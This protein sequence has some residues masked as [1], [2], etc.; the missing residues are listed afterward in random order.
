ME[1]KTSNL[2]LSLIEETSYKN[3]VARLDRLQDVTGN[4]L[5]WIL[6]NPIDTI[7]YI[8]LKISTNPRS[9]AN[10]IAPVC[11]L[12]QVHPRFQN[13]NKPHYATYQKYLRHY[14]K[15]DQEQTKK[16]DL[17][18][19]QEKNAVS[20][21]E[22]HQKYCSLKDN[23]ELASNF[24]LQQFYLLLSL[25]LNMH[26]K[27]A[28]LGNIK[29]YQRDP[30]STTHNFIFLKP[31]PHLVLNKYKTAKLRGAIREPLVEPL[32]QDITQSLANFPRTHLILG[33][34]KMQPYTKNN[35]YSQY[36][37]RAFQQH[38]GRSMGVGLWRIIFITAN[39]DFNETSY[40]DLELA[41]HY[42]G[43]S[44]QQE[45]LAYRKKPTSK[46]KDIFYKRPSD[47]KGEP[48]TC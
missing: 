42:K 46:N 38:F 41:A 15:A 21:Q 26:A 17:T 2:K 48:V 25:F 34:Q 28:D 29:I 19:K 7:K 10:Y 16:S 30:K 5:D 45:F 43:H 20:W 4:S 47:E 37:K 35:S 24:K 6:K 13:L 3:Y 11:K 14:R 22:V 31:K 36:V 39:V 8:K 44:V 33:P 27:R 23:P 18:E 40:E 1:V 32:V 12:F 9:L